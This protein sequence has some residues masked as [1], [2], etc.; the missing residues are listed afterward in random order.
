MERS[1]AI[2]DTA[3][4]PLPDQKQVDKSI[5]ELA[6]YAKLEAAKS[7]FDRYVCA[8][9]SANT[10]RDYLA[11]EVADHAIHLMLAADKRWEVYTT[12]TKGGED[13]K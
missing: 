7:R 11:I 3:T 10:N 1:E 13:A 5:H 6:R 4:I 12:T 9:E 2:R 8:V